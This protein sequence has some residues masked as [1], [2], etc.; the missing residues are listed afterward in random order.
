MFP[1]ELHRMN[2][3]FSRHRTRNHVSLNSPYT[4]KQHTLNGWQTKEKQKAGSHLTGAVCYST[5]SNFPSNLSRSIIQSNNIPNV[6]IFGL[7]RENY[8]KPS[9]S[10]VTAADVLFAK[11]A[12]A[13]HQPVIPG[14][15]QTGEDY[16]LMKWFPMYLFILILKICQVGGRLTEQTCRLKRFRE[17]IQGEEQVR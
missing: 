15:L 1:E 12:Q 16:I 4:S 14:W 9:C 13:G 2:G 10:C 17:V 7:N 5:D 11:P 3:F 6:S 8:A